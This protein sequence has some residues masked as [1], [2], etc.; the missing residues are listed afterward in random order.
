MKQR[1]K[2]SLRSL[3]V[4][5][6]LVALVIGVLQWIHQMLSIS[7]ASE[8]VTA[9]AQIVH[10]DWTPTPW[11]G[12][13]SGLSHPSDPFISGKA[14]P[15]QNA[16]AKE[17]HQIL[18]E[19]AYTDHFGN[20][21]FEITGRINGWYAPDWSDYLLRVTCDGGGIVDGACVCDYEFHEETRCLTFHVRQYINSKQTAKTATFRFV[22]D[23]ES[24]R[25]QPDSDQQTPTR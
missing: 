2:F 16:D 12:G 25:W 9:S 23:G 5:T 22:H 4:V 14:L 13:H 19:I 11:E 15:T 18:F 20:S 1:I 21:A 7:P 10:V 6:A 3:F 17:I 24:F 8:T